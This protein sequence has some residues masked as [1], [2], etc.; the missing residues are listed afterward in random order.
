MNTTLTVITGILVGSASGI[1]G[2]IIGSWMTG[3]SQLATLKAQISAEDA[4]A[5][6]SEKRELYIS[7]LTQVNEV[8]GIIVSYPE[9][10]EAE[11]RK[12][13]NRELLRV[14]KGLINALNTIILLAPAKVSKQAD[15]LAQYL[16]DCTSDMRVGKN[17]VEYDGS[18]SLD[19][20]GRFQDVVHADIKSSTP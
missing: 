13:A 18:K 3:K 12:L 20:V 8:I 19:L 10:E 6:I 17:S 15:A 9:P 14:E 5:R 11:Q 2:T 16:V 1:G 7:F 4:R